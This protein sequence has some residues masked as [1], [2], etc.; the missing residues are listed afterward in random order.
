MDG[1]GNYLDIIIFAV[2]AVALLFRLRS[3][4][5]TRSEDE[6]QGMPMA[7]A[8]PREDVA[9]H[10]GAALVDPAS[11]RWAQ[12]MPNFAIV[13]TATAHNNLT[14]FLAVDPSFRPHEFLEKARKAFEIIISAF[15]NGNRNTLEMLLSPSL[16]QAF[17]RQVDAREAKRETYFV[18]LH[19]IKK[20]IITDAHLDGTTAHVTVEIFAEQSITHK[21]DQGRIIDNN[22]GYRRKTHDRWVFVKDLKEAG[23][24][25][26]LENTLALED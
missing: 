9:A 18:T 21:D 7:Q 3:V 11:D 2:I 4:L 5:G 26:R 6:P 20:A 15:A 17:I 10:N 24:T 23:P 12:N 19:G 8:R 22:D 1:L 13:D 14:Q 16:Y 25:W